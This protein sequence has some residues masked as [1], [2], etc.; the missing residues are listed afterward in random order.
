[1]RR[2]LLI[3]ALA[4]L[5][6]C[7]TSGTVPSLAARP[8]EAVDPRVPVNRPIEAG[9]VDPQLASL[10]ATAVARALGSQTEFDRRAAEAQGLAPQAGPVGSESW[11]AAQAALSRLIEQQGVAVNAA[12]DVDGYAGERLNS[13]RWLSPTNQQAIADT[14][15]QIATITAAQAAVIDGLTT[16]LAR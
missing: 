3:L 6:A 1:M 14:A 9:A 10:L 8:A 13:Q 4:P 5:A 15:A 2:L 11:I 7:A 16:Q 12:A